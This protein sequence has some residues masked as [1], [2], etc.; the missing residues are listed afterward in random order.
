MTC[1][2]DFCSSPDVKWRYP[3]KTFSAYVTDSVA[4]E[5]LG[6]WAACTEVSRTNRAG[7]S[8]RLGRL[9]DR[10]LDCCPSGDGRDQR[11]ATS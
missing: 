1:I 5:S 6:D 2:C 4:G 10:I 3:A 8:R 9:V 11:G 7:R